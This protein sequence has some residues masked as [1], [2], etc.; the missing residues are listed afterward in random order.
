MCRY[1]LAVDDIGRNAFLIRAYG[2]DNA[3]CTRIDL[4]ATVADDADHHFLPTVFT[5]RLAAIPLTQIRNVL[6]DAMHRPRKQ[7]VILVV[8]GH[9]D[10]QLCPTRRVIMHLTEGEAAIFKVVRITSRG[11]IAHV[12]ELAIIFM[13]AEVKQLCWDCRVEHKVAVEESGQ[14]RGTGSGQLSSCQDE[15]NSTRT[16]RASESCA[17]VAHV[18]G[19]DHSGYWWMP[20]RLGGRCTDRASAE[21]LGNGRTGLG[22]GVGLLHLQD[23][24]RDPH[25]VEMQLWRFDCSKKVGE[26]R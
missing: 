12:S 10:E 14:A 23:R 9:D 19:C 17:Y 2:C 5:P 4:L 25:T 1:G 8:H 26:G 3:K 13:D 16:Q 7:A 20:P 24:D 22:A 6:H 18:A 11:R 21:P 15:L